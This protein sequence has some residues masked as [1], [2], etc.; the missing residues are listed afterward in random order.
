MDAIISAIEKTPEY[1]RYHAQARNA[2]KATDDTR[3]ALCRNSSDCPT[4]ICAAAAGAAAAI[5]RAAIVLMNARRVGDVLVGGVLSTRVA[6]VIGFWSFMAR[7]R[8]GAEGDTSPR[9]DFMIIVY[10]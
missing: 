3:V 7:V 5:G 8:A 9:L 1:W 4:Q 6:L 2:P 10:S